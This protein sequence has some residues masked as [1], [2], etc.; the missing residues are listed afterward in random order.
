MTSQ[1]LGK[2]LW[3][4][5]GKK[6][7]NSLLQLLLYLLYASSPTQLGKKSTFLSEYKIKPINL[8]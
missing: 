4:Q 2:E 7:E 3:C 8:F 1:A 6:L 5:V